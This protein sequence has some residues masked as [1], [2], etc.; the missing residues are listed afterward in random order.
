MHKI[1]QI[2]NLKNNEIKGLG[3]T[4]DKLFNDIE[5]GEL[6][7]LITTDENILKTYEEM[8]KDENLKD[9]LFPFTPIKKE[10][11]K[12]QYGYVFLLIFLGKTINTF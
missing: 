3:I 10:K 6:D 12:V 11:P 2:N 8:A 7:N 1:G 5:K 4:T 9:E